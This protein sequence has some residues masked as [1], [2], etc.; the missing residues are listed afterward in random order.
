MS[1]SLSGA[2]T[3][4]A[5]RRRTDSQPGLASCLVWTLLDCLPGS[6]EACAPSARLGGPRRACSAPAGHV[7]ASSTPAGVETV[8]DQEAF[9]SALTVLKAA[10]LTAGCRLPCFVKPAALRSAGRAP[11][12][13]CRRAPA[14]PEPGYG[15]ITI[16]KRSRSELPPMGRSGSE[17]SLRPGRGPL[18]PSRVRSVV[19]SVFEIRLR[20][21]ASSL[22]ND[23]PRLLSSW[24]LR[25]SRSCSIY[26]LYSS[27]RSS[28]TRGASCDLL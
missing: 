26:S 13:L 15:S 3:V 5:V 22:C 18:N 19:S 25:A 4:N 14:R 23:A 10:V 28:A 12:A 8:L 21:P 16:E 9:T 20:R 6:W 24:L 1:W 7:R 2:L 17:T 27:K 11:P